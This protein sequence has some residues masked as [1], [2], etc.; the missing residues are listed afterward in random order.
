M[1]KKKFIIFI[2]FFTLTSLFLLFL[3]LI[4]KNKFIKN[5]YFDMPFI[6]LRKK[7]CIN[8]D[9]LINKK[10][11][12]S[13]SVSIID[14]SGFIIS[15]YNSNKLRIPASNLKL[16]STGYVID[17]YNP[18]DSLNTSLF[19]DNKNN[20]YLIGSGDPDLSLKDVD[21]LL[22]IKDSN[23]EINFNILEVKEDYKWPEGWTYNDKLYNYGAPITS[24]AINSNNDIYLDKYY[25]KSYIYK[26]LKEKY[27]NSEINI[28]ILNY[29]NSLK[30][31]LRLF[32]N[33]KSNTILS[34]V[35]LANAESHNFTSESLFKNASNNW[36][37]NDYEKLKDWLYY[38]GFPIDG[39]S[40]NDASGLSRNNKITTKLISTFLYKM[41]F[42]RNFKAY[43]SSLSILGVRGTLANKLK[44]SNLSGK[45]FGKT[46]TLS[47]VFSLSGYLYK[48]DNT[49]IVSIIQNSNNIDINKTFRLISDIYKLDNC[50]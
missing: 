43:N 33:V 49:Y 10:L 22:K 39:I 17:K 8:Y 12:D 28:N 46:G 34:L 44:K 37:F 48:G 20:Y 11:D 18:Y 29:K 40:I 21:N 6:F 30:N 24:L 2:S 35:T 13:F 5:L 38:R 50:I 3:F 25:L 27:P 36:Q 41:R 45:F 23:K 31:K 47:N 26:N 19:L 42:N 16:L 14:K 9:N 4:D 1:I 32:K 15:E 7:K